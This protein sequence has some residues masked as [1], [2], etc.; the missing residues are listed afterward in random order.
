MKNS[1]SSGLES[2]EVVIEAAGHAA[3][4]EFVLRIRRLSAGFS[5]RLSGTVEH[6]AS[7]TADGFNS[8]GELAAFIDRALTRSAKAAAPARAVSRRAR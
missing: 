7:G 4:S 6:P 5:S 3:P 8:L 2:R 1:S